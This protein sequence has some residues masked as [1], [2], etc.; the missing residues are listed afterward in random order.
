MEVIP[1]ADLIDYSSVLDELNEMC[2]EVDCSEEDF[3][4]LNELE[5][6]IET[7]ITEGIKDW[8]VNNV[9]P[10]LQLV[11]SSHS[12]NTETGNTA[13]CQY[14]GQNGSFVINLED[15]TDDCNELLKQRLLPAGQR[16]KVN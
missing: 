8:I 1:E 15:P 6:S 9:D 3:E 2:E 7:S 13:W 5:E 16:V 12:G 14:K 4:E 11:S 10:T